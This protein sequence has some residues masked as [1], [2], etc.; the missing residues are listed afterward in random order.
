M[1]KKLSAEE[2]IAI[3][4][5]QLYGYSADYTYDS[6]SDLSYPCHQADDDVQAL[7]GHIAALEVEVKAVADIFDAPMPDDYRTAPGGDNVISWQQ[8]KFFKARRM[9]NEVSNTNAGQ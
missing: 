2:L 1:G 7:L 5:R 6:A 8:Y 3:R 4:E 9:L